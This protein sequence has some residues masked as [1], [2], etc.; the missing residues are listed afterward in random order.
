MFHL[1][2]YSV[3][4]LILILFVFTFL[5][6]GVVND[7]LKGFLVKYGKQWDGREANKIVGKTPLEAAATIVEDY[8]LPCAAEAFIAEITPV[9][10]DQ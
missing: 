2:L 3:T 6:D 4:S 10:S 8:G 5:A 1:L 7:V 9:F